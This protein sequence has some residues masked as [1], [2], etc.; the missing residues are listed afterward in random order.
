MKILLFCNAYNSLTQHVHT[1]LKALGHTIGIAIAT[2]S[3]TMTEATQRLEPDLIL[4]PMLTRIIPR[5]IWEHHLCIVLHP[6]V[7]GDRGPSSL[8]WAILT[9]QQEWG[10]IAVQAAEHVDSGPVWATSEFRM[11][12]ASKSSL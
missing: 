9:N 3:E 2:N 8:D 5:S 12:E 1:D 7:I 10:V 4:C 6:G 11:R